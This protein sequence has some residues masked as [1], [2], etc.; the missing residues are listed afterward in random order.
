MPNPDPSPATRFKPGNRANPGGKPHGPE[1]K[2]LMRAANNVRHLNE[3]WQDPAAWR[4]TAAEL[5]ESVMRDPAQDRDV[6]LHC[7]AALMRNGRQPADKPRYHLDA[8]TR[9]EKRLLETLIPKIT[10]VPPQTPEDLSDDPELAAV[11]RWLAGESEDDDEDEGED[12][13]APE[14][15]RASGIALAEPTQRDVPKPSV[16]GP[17][18]LPAPSLAAAAGGK[19]ACG[20]EMREVRAAASGRRR[21]IRRHRG[22]YDAKERRPW[23]KRANACCAPRCPTR[24]TTT[25]D[26]R[27][28][29][30]R[31]PI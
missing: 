29:P 17:L 7:A 11:A 28:N 23:M 5:I 27:L 19:R 4:G 26:A 15:E 3:V 30:F 10:G 9:R 13:P 8:L 31:N 25:T 14:P 12:E 21:A 2:T 1:R 22:G 16:A 6:R 18:A 24:T 20:L